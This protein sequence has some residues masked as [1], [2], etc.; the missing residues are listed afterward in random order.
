MGHPGATYEALGSSSGAGAG[1]SGAS[2]EHH[3]DVVRS[4]RW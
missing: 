2:G 3:A 4:C 1:G